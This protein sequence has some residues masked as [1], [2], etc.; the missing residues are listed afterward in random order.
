MKRIPFSS[1]FRRSRFQCDTFC[2]RRVKDPPYENKKTS[3]RKI[4]GWWVAGERTDVFTV[5]MQAKRG[6]CSML[7]KNATDMG[8]SVAVVHLNQ[9]FWLNCTAETRP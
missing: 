4:R 9:K 2:Y 5:K 7:N 3:H 8:T 6:G 1:D